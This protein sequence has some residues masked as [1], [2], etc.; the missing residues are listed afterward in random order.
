MSLCALVLSIVIN[1]VDHVVT[2]G[3]LRHYRGDKSEDSALNA[4]N[5]SVSFDLPFPYCFIWLCCPVEIVGN[6]FFYYLVIGFSADQTSCYPFI[7][8]W[9]GVQCQVLLSISDCRD[10]GGVV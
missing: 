1:G 6:S 8:L 7:A 10:N 2:G 5:K 4:I 9:M 3:S